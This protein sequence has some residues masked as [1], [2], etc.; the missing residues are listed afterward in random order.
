MQENIITNDREMNYSTFMQLM[1]ATEKALN[2]QI[3]DNHSMFESNIKASD[4]EEMVC[5]TV[6]ECAT[7]NALNVQFN[8]IS[9]NKFPD[10][11][12]AGGRF[13]IE[14]KSRCNSWETLGN[15]V[16]ESTRLEGIEKIYVAYLNYG[17]NPEFKLKPYGATLNDIVVTHMPRY[18]I[19]MD[20]A[21]EDDTICKKIVESNDELK[22]AL[23]NNFKKIDLNESQSGDLFYDV[24]RK[25][26]M[27]NENSAESKIVRNV[28][29]Y[30]REENKKTGKNLWWASTE[31]DGIEESAPVY[32]QSWAEMSKEDKEGYKI[33]L[34]TLY[35]KVLGSHYKEASLWLVRKGIGCHNLRDQF[36]AGGKKLIGDELYPAVLFRAYNYKEKIKEEIS[37][38]SD[39]ELK[40]A[41]QC[42]EI[43]D[44]RYLQ[45]AGLASYYYTKQNKNHKEYKKI[46][47]LLKA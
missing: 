27:L 22:K 39:D 9:G 6:N 41:W 16:L 29:D 23:E 15:S 28:I 10:L 24:L 8:R 30:F 31:I 17:S 46:F 4:V 35:P 2:E 20:M 1:A 21:K 14:V 3:R 37:R 34:F 32:L 40:E 36:T 12:L 43:E 33:R 19:K 18:K 25:D 38:L 11:A 42:K 5:K 47:K 44:N 45:W 7:N 26:G 13:G